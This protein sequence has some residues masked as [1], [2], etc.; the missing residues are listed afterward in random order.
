[1]NDRDGSVA[2]FIVGTVEPRRKADQ[3]AAAQRQQDLSAGH[4]L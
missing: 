3:A 4:V 2:F 1:M